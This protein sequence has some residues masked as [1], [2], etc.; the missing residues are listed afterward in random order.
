MGITSHKYS[1]DVIIIGSGPAGSAAA[2]FLAKS[3]VK[4]LVIEKEKLPRYKTCGGGIVGRVVNILPFDIDEVIETN[5]LQAEVYDADSGCHFVSER[6]YPIIRTTMRQNLDSFILSKA[7]E[8][9]AVLKDKC[10]VSN[11]KINE[12]GIEV[13]AGGDNLV[14]KFLIAADGAHGIVSKNLQANNCLIK[15]PALEYEVYTDTATLS[16]F[17]NKA[18]FDYGIPANGYGWVFPKRDHLS[19]GVIAMTRTHVNLN[20]AYQKYLKLLGI[21]TVLRFEKFGYTIP[22]AKKKHLSSHKRILF[23]GDSAGL[24]DPLTAEG[25]S[26]AIL[27]GRCAAESIVKADFNERTVT[28]L[29]HNAISDM[30]LKEHGYA[31]LISSLVFTSPKI[32]SFLFRHYGQRMSEIM[33]DI[34]SGKRKYSALLKNPDFYLKLFRYYLINKKHNFKSKCGTSFPVNN[35]QQF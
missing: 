22:F 25:I 23:A 1:Y 32:R 16:R 11:Y 19:I 10:E 30:I 15:L 28:N 3:G 21:D 31:K 18:R 35:I 13:Q 33:T 24:A 2:F 14:S 8:Q 34:S 29:Y 6:P 17:M 7:I 5:C 4:T 12:T 27:S 26:N 9:G 20:K